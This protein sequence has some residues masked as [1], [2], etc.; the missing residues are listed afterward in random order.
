MGTRVQIYAVNDAAMEA[1]DKF[2]AAVASVVKQIDWHGAR[3]QAEIDAG[4]LPDP[5]L[6]LGM[7]LEDIEGDHGDME[8]EAHGHEDDDAHAEAEMPGDGDMP[9]EGEAHG[10]EDDGMAAWM[11][12]WAGEERT[13]ETHGFL[14]P[15]YRVAAKLEPDADEPVRAVFRPTGPEP[16]NSFARPTAASATGINR[17]RCS[18]S[19]PLRPNKEE[20]HERPCSRPGRHL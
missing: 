16:S 20:G 3:A 14:I 8:G 5:E 4:R 9:G 13:L 7:T 18:S 17:A 11:M 1:M 10:H 2:P 6:L 15:W 12:P 19:S